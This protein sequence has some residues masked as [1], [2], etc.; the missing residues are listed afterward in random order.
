MS[1]FVSFINLKR[2]FS[3]KTSVFKEYISKNFPEHSVLGEEGGETD[4]NSD[5]LWVIDPLDG[6]I[7]YSQGLPVFAISIALQYKKETIL[8][9]VHAPF[10]SQTYT[11][12][13]GDGAYL[14]GKIITVGN[15]EKLNQSVIA[16]GFPYDR[17]IDLRYNN[18]NYAYYFIPKVKGIRRMGAAAYDL[19]CVASGALDGYW[20]MKLKPWDMA[21]GELIVKEAGGEVFILED[22]PA[23]A[24]IAGN[25]YI[26]NNIYNGIKEV[27]ANDRNTYT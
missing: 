12:V 2:H 26:V 16:T 5:Y 11:A 1:V 8:G 7:N 10:L 6:T 3:N 22:K 14:N 15:K 19:C 23:I 25:K 20:E 4:N 24:L 27:D 13:K 18:A 17:A 9:V 21:A